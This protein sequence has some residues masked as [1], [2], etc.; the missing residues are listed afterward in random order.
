MLL[1]RWQITAV[2]VGQTDVHGQLERAL[3]LDV[4]PHVGERF[5]RVG[6]DPEASDPQRLQL[7]LHGT[8]VPGEHQS[9]VSVNWRRFLSTPTF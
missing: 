9:F 6:G 2:A 7:D 5:A 8:G 1:G 4:Q 3:L